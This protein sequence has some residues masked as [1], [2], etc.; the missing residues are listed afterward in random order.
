MAHSTIATKRISCDDVRLR[1]WRAERGRAAGVNGKRSKWRDQKIKVG[2]EDKQTIRSDDSDDSDDS[3]EKA[4]RNTHLVFNER[5]NDV[6]T[7]V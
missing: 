3:D 7:A 6:F 4:T 5:E 1:T 2:G